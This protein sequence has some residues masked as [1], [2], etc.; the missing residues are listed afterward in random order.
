MRGELL[1]P[2]AAAAQAVPQPALQCLGSRPCASGACLRQPRPRI[3]CHPVQHVLQPACPATCRFPEKR[4][5]LI[6]DFEN[7]L[8]ILKAVRWQLCLTSRHICAAGLQ[9]WVDAAPCSP[10]LLHVL[11]R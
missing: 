8:R 2:P 11:W 6:N 10:L 5:A 1:R 4:D 3:N 9:A 7:Y